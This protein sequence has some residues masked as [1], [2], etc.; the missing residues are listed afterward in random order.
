MEDILDLIQDL[1]WY[2]TWIE[3]FSKEVKSDDYSFVL[4]YKHRKLYSNLIKKNKNYI[5]EIVW[6]PNLKFCV[7]LFTL[8]TI[9][10]FNKC[11]RS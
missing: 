4:E 1:H 5:F 10:A 7:S 2:N 8:S 9:E 11:W 3:D 6:V